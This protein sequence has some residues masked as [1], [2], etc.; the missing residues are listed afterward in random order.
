MVFLGCYGFFGG[1]Y[2][3]LGVLW[4]FWGAMGFLGYYGV[5]GVL[6]GFL[7]VLWGFWGAGGALTTDGGPRAPQSLVE[8]IEAAPGA[9]PVKTPQ[10]HPELAG[11]R[12]L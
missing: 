6:W 2:V 5:L 3:F 9:P 10:P 1:Y 8:L 4:V 7:G 12:G 11:D